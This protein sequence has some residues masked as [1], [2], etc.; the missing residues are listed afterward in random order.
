[1]FELPMMKLGGFSISGHWNWIRH[2]ASYS[3]SFALLSCRTISASKSGNHRGQGYA[4]VKV[5]RNM[6]IIE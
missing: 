4:A 1:V 6:T 3:L 5:E 2:V